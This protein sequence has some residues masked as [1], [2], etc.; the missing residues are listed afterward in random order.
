MAGRRAIR[1]ACMTVAA[2]VAVMLTAV[3]VV[4]HGTPRLHLK[5]A[6]DIARQVG[7][8]YGDTHPRIVSLVP[9]QTD[10]P[11]HD[12]MYY[13]TL[14]G[15]FHEGYRVAHYVSFSAL[16]DKAYVWGVMGYNHLG[17]TLWFDDELAPL[18]T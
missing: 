11:P 16:A 14:A 6:D 12:P 13:I 9:T 7:K 17:S 3:I 4:T 1:T 2:L 18:P 5:T 8:H 15:H 10:N